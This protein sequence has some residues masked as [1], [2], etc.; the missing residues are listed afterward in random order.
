MHSKRDR[1]VEKCILH[2]EHKRRNSLIK[3]SIQT[4]SE[5]DRAQRARL[6][7]TAKRL[8]SEFLSLFPRVGMISPSACSLITQRC[9][10]AERDE[11]L[12]PS[13]KP[14]WFS[15]ALASLWI[16]E[17]LSN[18]ARSKKERREKTRKLTAFLEIRRVDGWVSENW[19]IIFSL[20]TQSRCSD[21]R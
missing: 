10:S 1:L 8:A 11:K 5:Q 17:Y 6:S 12:S 7:K 15:L 3:D 9:E 14:N 18:W 4:T 20:H 21:R 13:R 2:T 19:E 16:S